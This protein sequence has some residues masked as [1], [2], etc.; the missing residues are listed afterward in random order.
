MS[1]PDEGTIREYYDSRQLLST[2]N[3]EM[4]IT[5]CNP[6]YCQRFLDLGRLVH[7]RHGKFD[8][9]WGLVVNFQQRKAPRN[10]PEEYPPNE[11]I[12]VDVLLE[13]S[14]NA[15]QSFKSD[16]PLPPGVL[17]AQKGE[18]ST[19]AVVP[20][21]LSCI[22]SFSSLRLGIPKELK[23]PESRKHSQ[24]RLAETLRRFPDGVPVLDPLN[25]MHIKDESFKRTL[26]VG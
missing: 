5:M 13:I 24:K 4:R 23:S 10:A 18:K 12:I 22:Q 1:I 8:F 15:P 14:E 2:Y 21:V 25:D 7:V 20:V 26:R 17:P 9:G 11:S 6:Q 16:Q 19:M 3:E